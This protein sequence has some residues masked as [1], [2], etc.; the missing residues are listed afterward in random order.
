MQIT[1]PGLFDEQS[2]L[3]QRLMYDL[4]GVGTAVLRALSLVLGLS[5]ERSLESSHR[6]NCLST[7]ALG[8][9]RYP[10]LWAESPRLGHGAHTDVGSLTLLFCSEAGLQI[11][12]A[13]TERWKDVQ[14]K[15]GHAIVNVGDSL[16]F[17]S[18]RRLRSCLHRVV[19]PADGRLADRTSCAYFL[20]PELDTVLTDDAGQSWRS[21]DWHD[22]K[23]TR[24][25]APIEKQQQDSIL[26][27]KAGFVGAW[28]LGSK[29]AIET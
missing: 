25:R 6:P 9:L 24:F 10:E 26:T 11:L 5:F 22:R 16:H 3:I 27:G 13:D 14:P 17:L 1:L 18:N 12:E 7:S 23:Y 4:H 20:R 2:S 8:V 19:P 28:C 21:V 15:A 29:E